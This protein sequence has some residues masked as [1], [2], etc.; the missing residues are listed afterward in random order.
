MIKLQ[1]MA[2]ALA[3]WG[4]SVLV[5]SAWAGSNAKA[6]DGMPVQRLSNGLRVVVIEDHRA[7]V[8]LT[9][10]WYRVGSSDE[11]GG[12]TGISHYLEHMLF[13]GTKRYPGNRFGELIYENGG[14]SN[15]FTTADFT[16]YHETM[17]V[18]QLKLT[19]ALEADR[20]QHLILNQKRLDNEKKVIIEERRMRVEDNP[21]SLAYE[22]FKA[23]A[24]INNPYHHPVIGWMTDIKHLTLTDLKKWYRRYYVPNNAV[25]IVVGD[26]KPKVVLD[27]AKHYFGPIASRPLPLRKPRTEVASLGRRSLRLSLPGVTAPWL[28]LGYPAPSITTATR[29]WQPYALMVLSG[30]LAGDNSARMIDDLVRRRSLAS[31]LSTSYSPYHL[32]ST[33][34]T[35]NAVPAKGIPLSTLKAAILRW[36]THLSTHPFTPED[37]QRVK[38]QLIA[39]SIFEQDSLMGQAFK[40]GFPLMMNQPWLDHRAW[41]E[42]I[43]SVTLGQVNQMA[44]AVLQLSQLKA[45]I[46]QPLA[47]IRGAL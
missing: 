30:L 19:F 43:G 34:F 31:G 10:I 20:M 28:I 41:S 21:Q 12:I 33:L 35:V 25:L 37:I 3:I 32:Y 15:A 46:L 27:L 22:R 18:G 23:V 14:T 47:S 26:V 40:A 39:S 45:L 38:A 8:V 16:V 13:R 7:P 29:D 44:E 5:A 17:P 2:K 24:Y 36:F 11:H 4:A 6:V 9:S 42:R 1:G